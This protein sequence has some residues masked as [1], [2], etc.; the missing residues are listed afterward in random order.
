MWFI[1]FPSGLIAITFLIPELFKFCHYQVEFVISP[2]LWF[3]TK[4]PQN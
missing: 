1:W 2:M 3:R 4:Q